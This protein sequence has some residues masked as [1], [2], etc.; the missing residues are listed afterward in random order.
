MHLT[1]DRLH[2]ATDGPDLLS[3]SVVAACA[4]NASLAAFPGAVLSIPCLVGVVNIDGLH[5]V[6][7]R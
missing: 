3:V 5:G 7:F 1:L 6:L 2:L 4:W